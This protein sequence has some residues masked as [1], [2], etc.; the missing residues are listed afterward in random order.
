MESNYQITNQNIHQ[1][2]LE[3]T[4]VKKYKELLPIGDYRTCDFLVIDHQRKQFFMAEKQNITIQ[5]LF[6]VNHGKN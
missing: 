2:Y 3:L 1:N 4:D 5:K 6:N